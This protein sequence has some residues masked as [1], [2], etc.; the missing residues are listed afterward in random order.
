MFDPDETFPSNFLVDKVYA[1]GRKQ[2]IRSGI[3]VTSLLLTLYF[4]CLSKNKT[5]CGSLCP[6]FGQTFFACLATDLLCDGNDL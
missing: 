6:M 3:C 4:Q 1:S 2:P 5:F